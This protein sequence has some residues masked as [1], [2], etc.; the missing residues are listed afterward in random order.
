MRDRHTLDDG[1]PLPLPSLVFDRGFPF[2][3][4][5]PIPREEEE[6]ENADQRKD[7]YPEGDVLNH[8]A[9]SLCRRRI[10]AR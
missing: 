3:D 8:E 1:G 9:G 7:S 5:M 2:D 6:G 4:S 10:S